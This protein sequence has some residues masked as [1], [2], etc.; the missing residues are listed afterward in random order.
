MATE[1]LDSR[2]A[3]LAVSDIEASLANQF[4]ADLRVIQFNDF[5]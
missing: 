2:I 4:Y 3:P 1:D 5:C